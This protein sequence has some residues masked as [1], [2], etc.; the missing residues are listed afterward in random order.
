MFNTSHAHLM[1]NEII[2]VF[3]IVDLL[4]KISCESTAESD[5]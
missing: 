2:F 5:L 3:I 1:T 4:L